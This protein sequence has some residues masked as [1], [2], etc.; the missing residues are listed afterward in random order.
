MDGEDDMYQCSACLEWY[1]ESCTVS[2]SL[3]NNIITHAWFCLVVDARGNQN[4]QGGSNSA[5]FA[6]RVV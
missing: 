5:T 1:H 2:L 6:V 3:T 4:G